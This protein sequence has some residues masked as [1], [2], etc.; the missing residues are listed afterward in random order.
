[1]HELQR[2]FDELFLWKKANYFEPEI[3]GPK[4]KKSEEEDAYVM[5]LEAPGLSQEEIQITVE[6]DT[7]N[8]EG[9]R[10][11]ITPDGYKMLRQERP[12]LN[13]QFEETL[14]RGVNNLA[15]S[16]KLE[17]GILSIYLPK[18]EAVRPHVIEVNANNTKES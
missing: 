18:Q 2:N 6:K 9:K 1:M 7:I 12:E 16:A 3:L 13:F 5:Q 14:P 15:V 10:E 4:L 8:I 17:E 11:S